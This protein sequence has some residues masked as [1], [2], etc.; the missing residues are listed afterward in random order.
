[1]AQRL[2]L[3]EVRHIAKL[4]RLKLS[5]ADLEQF[6]G[7]L[8]SVLDHVAR[9]NE[10]DV[11]GIEPMYQP[12]DLVNRLDEDV[13]EPSLDAATVLAMSPETEGAF[14]AVPKV[15]PGEEP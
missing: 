14:L 2:S 6:T 5:D 3:D 12:S 11:E 4:A 9:L 10:L 13:V 7:Q 1:M 8:S 15:L